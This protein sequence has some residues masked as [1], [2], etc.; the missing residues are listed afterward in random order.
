[1]PQLFFFVIVLIWKPVTNYQLFN[2]AVDIFASSLPSLDNR[3]LIR[4]ELAHIWNIPV[5]DAD[6]LCSSKPFFE[7]FIV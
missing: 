5:P 7:V 4:R 3:L 1:M 2:Q 6:S